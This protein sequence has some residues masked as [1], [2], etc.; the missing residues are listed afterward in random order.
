MTSGTAGS[1]LVTSGSAVNGLVTSGSL[2]DGSEQYGGSVS[3]AITLLLAYV[4]WLAVMSVK[5]IYYIVGQGASLAGQ[6]A[7]GGFLSHSGGAQLASTRCDAHTF[8]IKLSKQQHSS[9][10]SIVAQSESMDTNAL[11]YVDF[12]LSNIVLVSSA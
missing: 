10:A 5:I 1:G 8:T 6:E 3:N 7:P 9:H 12:A 2:W 4:L 11:C